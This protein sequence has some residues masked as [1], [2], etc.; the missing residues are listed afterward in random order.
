M[1]TAN[2]GARHGLMAGIRVADFS[3]QM[4]GP[5][6]TKH[7]SDLG[8]EVIMVESSRRPGW[9]RGPPLSGSNDQISTSKLSVTINTRDA[10]GLELAKQLIARSDV[11]VENYAGGT[12][13]RMGLGYE[14]V[15][16]IKPDIIMLSSS[17]QG[18]TGP[19][20]THHGSGHKLTAL[21]GLNQIL[22]WPDRPPAWIGAY[23]D[24][25]APRYNII[26]IMA[27]LDYRRRTGKGQYLD[28]SQLEASLQFMSP[29]LLDYAVNR[30][31]ATR[32]GNRSPWAAPHNAYRCL[33]EDRWCVIAVYTDREW[34]SLCRVIGD[35]ALA[36]VRFE[37]MTARKEHEEEL[38]RLISAWT[39]V[40][41]AEQV[42][43]SLQAAGVAAGVAQTGEDLLD[44]DP[45]LQHRRTFATLEYPGIGEYRSQ[46]GAHFLMS[47][48]HAEMTA[49]PLMGQHNE[50]VF[51]GILGMSDPQYDQLVK[52][53]VID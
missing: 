43:T 24:F 15:S 32:M 52:D 5:I 34:G 35:P 3:W 45:Q 51:K 41:P 48:Y 16:A 10:R 26:A 20:S 50:Y 12:I 1:N 33:G 47:K 31:V 18:Q 38:D 42:M 8:A 36:D 29:L 2:G 37:T 25:I 9:R 22:G 27:A 13:R 53:G 6:T 19:Y 21:A 4:T 14:V 30:R 44:H 28:M 7:L 23:T 17:M 39:S 11:M 49:A 46:A 40:R